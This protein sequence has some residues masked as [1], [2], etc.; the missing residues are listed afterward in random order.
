M[1][2]ALAGLPPVD[3]APILVEFRPDL[4]AWRGRLLSGETRGRPVHAAS[5]PRVRQIVLDSALLRDAVE[6]RR[7]TVHELHHFAWIRMSNADRAAYGELVRPQVELRGELG[8][9]AEG[10]KN[11]LRAGDLEQRTRRWREYVCESFCDTAAWHYSRAESHPEWTLARRQR[12]VRRAWF[13]EFFL[14]RPLFL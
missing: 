7:I 10:L 12:A 8:W 2:V 4:T 1:G 5:H 3:G 14:E 6:L 9:S 13:R 11:S